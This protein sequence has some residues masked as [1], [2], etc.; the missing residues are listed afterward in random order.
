MH[1]RLTTAALPHIAA[2]ANVRHVPA[3][4]YVQNQG[5][6]LVSFVG[7]SRVPTH[8]G[9]HPLRYGSSRTHQLVV[10]ELIVRPHYA[11]GT[12]VLRGQGLGGLATQSPDLERLL[13]CGE[14]V[15]DPYD[16]CP[17]SR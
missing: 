6:G 8:S 2:D 10:G 13:D 4:L 1:H 11:I 16:L 5:D 3:W 12:D 14:V 17:V 9:P 15:L 7:A